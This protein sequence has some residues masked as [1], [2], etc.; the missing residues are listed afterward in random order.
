M[1]VYVYAANILRLPVDC[2]VNSANENLAHGSGLAKIIEAAAG[3]RM[4]ADCNAYVRRHG[5]VPVGG[6]YTSTAGDLPY[7]CVIHAIGPRWSDYSPYDFQSIKE[8]ESLLQDAII[9]SFVEA[10]KRHLK[11]IALPA[12]RAGEY[13]RCFLPV[14]LLIVSRFINHK[15][16]I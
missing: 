10:E 12:I 3:R 1:K 5:P 15:R 4:T 13:L 8:C 7:A 6:A 2:I 14:N 11:T 16:V 9:S